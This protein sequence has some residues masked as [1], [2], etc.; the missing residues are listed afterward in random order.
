MLSSDT[1]TGWIACDVLEQEVRRL[2]LEQQAD[3]ASL[4]VLPMGLHDHPDNLRRE[5]QTQV[6]S[7][8]ALGKQRLIFVFGLCS[9]SILGLRARQ[10][11]MIFPRAHSCIT[12]FLGSK[13]RYAA[14]HQAEPGTY[15]YSPG[16]IRGKRVPGPHHFESLQAQYEQKFEEDDVA[17]LMEMERSKFAHYTTAA[18]T[19]LEKVG[20]SEA[21]E[22]ARTAAGLLGLRFQ[23]HAGDDGLL[24]RLLTGPWVDEDFL[25]VPPGHTAAYS[26]DEQILRCNACCDSHGQAAQA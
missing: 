10:A 4:R 25:V 13:E 5:L 11:V 20:A 26:A 6:D 19:D 8:E 18:Y 7:L 21:L 14:C 16:W 12:L 3:L 15:W 24:R 22:Q 1:R 17:Y 2:L 23:H 9:N